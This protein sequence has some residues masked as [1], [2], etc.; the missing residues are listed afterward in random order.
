MGYYVEGAGKGDRI[1]D[2]FLLQDF[3]QAARYKKINYGF[4]GCLYP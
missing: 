1:D 2:Y 3:D 4:I